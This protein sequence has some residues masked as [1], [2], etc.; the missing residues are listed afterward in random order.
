MVVA[1]ALVGACAPSYE[2]VQLQD[3]NFPRVLDLT[4]G[5]RFFVD[6]Q[7]VRSTRTP[8][9]GQTTLVFK[10]MEQ[11]NLT[12][13]CEVTLPSDDPAVTLTGMGWE[14]RVNR[15]TI[16]RN[17]SD[18]SCANIRVTSGN[19]VTTVKNAYEGRWV[20]ITVAQ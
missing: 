15:E 10:Q 2:P 7:F 18:S 16:V 8:G 19:I 1:M 9:V 13:Y 3:P 14:V 12:Y 17:G 11:T 5:S 4:N 20:T 6:P